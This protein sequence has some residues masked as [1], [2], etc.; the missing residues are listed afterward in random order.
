MTRETRIGVAAIAAVVGIIGW[1]IA[2]GVSN[3]PTAAETLPPAPAAVTA[4]AA[5]PPAAHHDADRTKDGCCKEK[6]HHDHANCKMKKT[7]GAPGAPEV[8]P[9]PPLDDKTAAAGKC[10][11]LAGQAS[12]KKETH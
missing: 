7:A 5:E 12:S 2:E 8:V 1:S 10:P 6:A 4:P 9:A 11:Y 3:R